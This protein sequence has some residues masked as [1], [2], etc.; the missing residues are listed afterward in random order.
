MNES[1]REKVIWQSIKS[2]EQALA[3]I[4]KLF[5]VAEPGVVFG[6]PVSRG[7]HTVIT[8]SEIS[9]G[10]GFGLGSGGGLSGEAG[11]QGGDTSSGQVTPGFGAGAGGGG[12]ALGRPVAAIV[13]SSDGVRVEP[14]IDATKVALAFLAFVGSVTV[15]LARAAKRRH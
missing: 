9:M 4:E 1:E 7:D 5:G 12:G 3:F 14:I 8:A 13:I 11:A 15:L 2:N 10:G 6:E